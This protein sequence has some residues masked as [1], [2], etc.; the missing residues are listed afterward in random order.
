MKLYIPEIGD[1]FR[2]TADWTFEL[3][4][5]SRNHSLWELAKADG[6]KAIKAWEER[7]EALMAEMRRLESYRVTEFVQKPNY[8]Y[9]FDRRQPESIMVE[10]KV[11]KNPDHQSEYDAIRTNLWREDKP[12][13][14]LTLPTKTLLSVDRIYIRKGVSEY[15]SI[16]FYL[17]ETTWSGMPRKKKGATRFWAKLADVNLIECER[18]A[19]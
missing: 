4:K 11:W 15:S 10:E 8:G 1:R 12:H 9:R 6:S 13:V 14:P 19:S 3:Y 7:R 2:L 17:K 18:E 16:T 5:E